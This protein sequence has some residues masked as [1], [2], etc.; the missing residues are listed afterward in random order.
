MDLPLALEQL[1][2]TGRILPTDDWGPCANTGESYA[3]FAK[4]WRGKSP[5][6][7]AAE[8]QAAFAA[9]PAPTEAEKMAK[10]PSK[11]AV[12]AAL[13]LRA[14]GQWATMPAQ[15]KARVQAIIDAEAVRI[16]EQLG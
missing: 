1:T 14:S 5:V 11:A 15:R 10:I 4:G 16:I 2:R 8:L 3:D 6:P 9:I 13:T 12:H 7:T